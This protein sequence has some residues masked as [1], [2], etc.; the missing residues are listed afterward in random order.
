[1]HEI[2]ADGPAPHDLPDIRRRLYSVP[3][4]LRL[5]FAQEE[6]RDAR[7]SDVMVAAA[8]P[9]APEATNLPGAERQE[10]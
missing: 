5:P 6:E 1:M 2:P 8:Q 10:A 4:V 7:G 3:A 9:G